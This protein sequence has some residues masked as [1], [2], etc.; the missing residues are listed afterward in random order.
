MDLL[1]H[2]ILQ[3]RPPS[4]PT[5]S[6]GNHTHVTGI[7]LRG[8]C[9][10]REA[11]AE[12]SASF[13]GPGAMTESKSTIASFSLFRRCSSCSP[14]SLAIL[15]RPSRL[16]FWPGIVPSE[17]PCCPGHQRTQTLAGKASLPTSALFT[18]S[19]ASRQPATRS[20]PFTTS[21][22]SPSRTSSK[23]RSR[24]SPG[25]SPASTPGRRNWDSTTGTPRTRS[26]WVSWTEGE[27]VNRPRQRTRI[28]M[29]GCL[30]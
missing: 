23:T 6:S 12:M 1:S 24:S 28:R 9:K 27:G 29:L 4:N 8:W 21:S 19:C 13:F 18:S 2:H 10:R 26:C 30:S 14:P 16:L 20:R 5:S 17:T 15:R 7:S 22:R 11:N 25:P 3:R